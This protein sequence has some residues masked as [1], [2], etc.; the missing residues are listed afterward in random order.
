MSCSNDGFFFSPLFSPNKA[1]LA[2]EYTHAAASICTCVCV[3]MCCV[4]QMWAY[5]IKM[6]KMYDEM[7][8][9]FVF[10]KL[11]SL[12]P[13]VICAVKGVCVC[14]CVSAMASEGQ[15]SFFPHL[16]GLCSFCALHVI[17]KTL[18][19]TSPVLGSFVC[20]SVYFC[21]GSVLYKSQ[22]SLYISFFLTTESLTD[23]YCL[24]SGVSVSTVSGNAFYDI[25]LV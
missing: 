21:S 16:F 9:M 5:V 1:H 25:L 2:W 11:P 17:S 12:F 3:C 13:L 24:I 14:V 4:A 18:R 10:F 19:V 23:K 20:A 8:E 7:L 22:W 15:G 6:L